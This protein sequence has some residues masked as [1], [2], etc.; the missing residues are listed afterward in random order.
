MSY[1]SVQEALEHLATICP[2]P[3][4]ESADELSC[5]DG[6]T[7]MREHLKTLKRDTRCIC[8]MK[9]LMTRGHDK[10]CADYKKGGK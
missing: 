10:R 4:V 6:E 5:V 2:V 3:S 1:K 8:L 7:F 9:D